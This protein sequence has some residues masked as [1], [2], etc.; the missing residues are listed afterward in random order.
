MTTR[1][2]A[3]SGDPAAGSGSADRPLSEQEVR[4]VA[5]QAP[6]PLG[7]AGK[8]QARAARRA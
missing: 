7:L 1:P 2:W 3:P 5:A 4:D 8:S 6:A